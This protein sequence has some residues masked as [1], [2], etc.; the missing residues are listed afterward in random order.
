MK[1][2]GGRKPEPKQHHF[3]PKTFKNFTCQSVE[4]GS[5]AHPTGCLSE[6]WTPLGAAETLWWHG[7][8]IVA[9]TVRILCYRVIFLKI[10]LF[11]FFIV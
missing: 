11:L 3:S 7:A 10:Y 5:V 4:S 8:I 2:L 9:V 1:D 6:A